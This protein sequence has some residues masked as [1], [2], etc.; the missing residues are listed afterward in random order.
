[1]N[2]TSSSHTEE[3]VVILMALCHGITLK[4]KLNTKNKNN[5]FH[6]LATLKKRYCYSNNDDRPRQLEEN[7]KIIHDYIKNY[8]VEKTIENDLKDILIPSFRKKFIDSFGS[9]RRDKLKNRWNNVAELSE[10]AK[11]LVT[12]DFLKE[13]KLYQKCKKGDIKCRDQFTSSLQNNP[14]LFFTLTNTSNIENKQIMCF[15]GSQESGRGL[16]VIYDTDFNTLKENNLFKEELQND[17]NLFKSI[18]RKNGDNYITFQNIH[19]LYTDYKI[20]FFDYS[21]DLSITDPIFPFDKREKMIEDIFHY[22]KSAKKKKDDDDK[23]DKELDD[24]LKSSDDDSGN[25]ESIENNDREKKVKK[26]YG[27]DELLEFSDDES[28]NDDSIENN[29]N[30][31]SN[32]RKVEG[33][34]LNGDEGN[35]KRRQVEGGTKKRKRSYK[36]KKKTRKYKNRGKRKTRKYK[37]KK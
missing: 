19:D 2:Q 14:D 1:M 37:K 21:C 24:L 7:L 35:K 3:K 33:E 10:D 8:N 23:W 9:N 15:N 20:I 34:H 31:N 28:G 13:H 36:K 32:K 4:T 5:F 29:A 27:M 22:N 11:L 17:K 25:D 30:I 26:K 18:H 12:P 16:Y 6:V